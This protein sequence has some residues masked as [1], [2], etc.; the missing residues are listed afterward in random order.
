MRRFFQCKARAKREAKKQK[1][2]ARTLARARFFCRPE[3]AIRN[4]KVKKASRPWR[5]AK[6]AQAVSHARLMVFALFSEVAN[7]T[8][9]DSKPRP[10]LDFLS[11]SSAG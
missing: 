9:R 10:R 6:V 1:N 8:G 3:S 5:A 4:P 7:R 11:P 2:R